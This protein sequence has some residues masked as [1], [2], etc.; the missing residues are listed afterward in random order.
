M[1][2][3][4]KKK[5]K[6]PAGLEEN[7]AAWWEKYP[8]LYDLNHPQWHRTDQKKEIL[9][10]KVRDLQESEE[11]YNE[12]IVKDLTVDI[13]QKWMFS[14]RDYLQRARDQGLSGQAAKR[15][16]DL[17]QRRQRLFGFLR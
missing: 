7:L 13:L 2:P 16:T 9:R 1:A 11:W 4:G 6:L 14:I 12:D 5:T 15:T 10:L 17:L 3:G 8:Q